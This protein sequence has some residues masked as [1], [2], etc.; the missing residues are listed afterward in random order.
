MEFL[1]TS[2]QVEQNISTNRHFMQDISIEADIVNALFQTG[3]SSVPSSLQSTHSPSLF[4]AFPYITYIHL[5]P[6]IPFEICQTLLSA[7]PFLICSKETFCPKAKKGETGKGLPLIRLQTVVVCAISV[8]CSTME[9]FKCDP[10]VI[11]IALCEVQSLS[12]VTLIWCGV[13]T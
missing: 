11:R 2:L 3:S 6:Q 9:H 5:Q 7:L 4:P 10:K 1:I 12:H 8:A 13:T